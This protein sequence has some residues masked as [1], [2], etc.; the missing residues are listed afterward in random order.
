MY[1]PGLTA[2]EGIQYSSFAIPG[3]EI[4]GWGATNLVVGHVL[5]ARVIL[6]NT[7]WLEES[8]ILATVHI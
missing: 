5:L 8:L 1:N 6:G 7:A 3:R 4:P 2:M